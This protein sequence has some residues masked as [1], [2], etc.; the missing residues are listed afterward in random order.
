MSS[1]TETQ[2]PGTLHAGD[3]VRVR[4]GGPLMTVSQIQGDQ[5]V[6]DWTENGEM[7][8]GRF[9]VAVLASRLT[10]PPDFNADRDERTVDQYYQKHCPS[11]W[12]SYTGKFACAY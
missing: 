1:S 2:N 5:V 11:G 3:L 9:P 8:S 12:L 10:A 4:S 7:R 6:C